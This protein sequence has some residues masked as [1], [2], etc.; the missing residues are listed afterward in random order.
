MWEINKHTHT[1]GEQ[2]GD[3]QRGRRC[4]EGKRGKGHIYMVTDKNWTVD[5]EHN[6]VYTG[7]KI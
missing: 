5:G 4:G 2:I 3:Y 6:A 1:E 7:A